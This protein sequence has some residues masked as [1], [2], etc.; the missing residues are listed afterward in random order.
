MLSSCWDPLC[1]SQNL[2]FKVPRQ[3]LTEQTGC[4]P[5]AGPGR[6]RRGRAP[7]WAV[8]GAGEAAGAPADTGPGVGPGGAAPPSVAR[9]ADSRLRK[10]EH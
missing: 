3:L 9:A 8:G 4:W 5:L 6:G 2:N 10:P 1:T 7:R